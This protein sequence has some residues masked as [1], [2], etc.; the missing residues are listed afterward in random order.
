MRAGVREFARLSFR[1]AGTVTWQP[2]DAREQGIWLSFH[3]L[4]RLGNAIVWE[5]H[6]TP[7]PHAIAP[8][9]EITLETAIRGPIPPGPYRLA[10]DLVDEGRCWF[11]EVGNEPLQLEVDVLPRL[12]ERALAV[13]VVGAPGEL[14]AS[15]R[16]ALER[17]SEPIAASAQIVAHLAAGCAPRPDWASRILDAHDEGYAIIG[18][19]VSLE[20]PPLRHRKIKRQ[21]APWSPGFGRRPNWDRPLACPSIAIEAEKCDPMQA[22]LAGLPAVDPASIAEP[23]LCDGRI[24][25]DVPATAAQPADRQRV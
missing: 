2:P 22:P 10:F 15:T 3:W 12:L 21:L 19:A 6:R 7:L 1:N 8:G 5:G 14:E 25:V 18:G 9:Q 23:W 24:V 13:V 16:L 17:Q 4:D 11:A 20:A